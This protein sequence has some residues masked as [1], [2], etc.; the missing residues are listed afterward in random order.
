MHYFEMLVGNSNTF[1]F[2]NIFIYFLNSLQRV[3]RVSTY[4]G[5]L[6]GKQKLK[7]GDWDKRE[8]AV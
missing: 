7:L 4:D 3:T 5:C 6:S 2:N 8:E 1:Y